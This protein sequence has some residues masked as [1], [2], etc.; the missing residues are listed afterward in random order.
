M[1]DRKKNIAIM[2]GGRSVEHEI[3]VISGLQVIKAMD[4]LKY[5]PIPVYIAPSGKWYS[6]SQLLDRSFYKTIPASLTQLQ[7]V[8]CLPDPSVRGLTVVNTAQTSGIGWFGQKKPM[9]IP[10]DVYFPAFHGSF[11]ED[12]CL[13]GLLEMADAAYAGCGV[14]SSAICM[15]KHHSKTVV[16][17]AGVPMLPSITVSKHGEGG[18][19][20]APDLGLLRNKILAA[21]GLEK[22][23]LFVKP[24]TLGSSIGVSR[25]S[26]ASELDASLL[27]AFQYDS[28]AIVE[29]CLTNK[30]EINVS[31]LE[32]L[33]GGGPIASVVEIP[34][35]AAGGELTYEDKY[36]RGGGKKTGQE[37][38][39]MAGLVRVIDPQD[40]DT[41]IKNQVQKY[42]VQAFKAL[43]C[44]G[45]VRIDFMQDL[46]SGVIYFNEINPLP[47]SFA[48]YL[49]EKNHPPLLFTDLVSIM[50]E[51]A[52]KRHQ[53][54]RSLTT[55][56][57]FK[58]LS[59]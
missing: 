4:T 2:F 54:K 3:S 52:E 21:P 59:K 40:L 15:S 8:T 30:L 19:H 6:G 26:D 55:Q 49:W 44:T 12:G 7:E 18:S 23:P 32:N 41:E 47:G 11:G 24:A 57:G 27:K 14:T 9:V 13:Q 1:T 46:D 34:I 58:A 29:P 35:P 31:I 22:F 56:V 37:P 45:L 43:G 10:V 38:E 50:I 48:F 36:L 42:G 51:S 25:A 53:I 33:A 16:A 28:V 39:G 17:A 20:T 5:N